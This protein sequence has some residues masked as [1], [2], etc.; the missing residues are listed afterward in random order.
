M[1]NGVLSTIGGKSANEKKLEVIANNMANAL[2]PGFKAVGSAFRS[3][4]VEDASSPDQLPAIAVNNPDNYIQFSDGPVIH[5]GNTLDL[6]IEGQGFFVVSGPNGPLYTRNGQFRLNGA[7]QLITQDGYPV[8]GQS[9][10]NITIDGKNVTIEKDGSIFV[11]KVPVDKVKVV[12]FADKKDLRNTGASLFVNT[13]DANTPVP[14]K[15]SSV[16][17]GSYEASNV[18]I[19]K[20]MVLMIQV[21]RAYE[22]YSKIDQSQATMA[23][24]LLELGKF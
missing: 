6:A 12:D 19:M 1:L 13:N 24:K 8:M 23:D 21:L 10:G 2:T 5:T 14:A 18:D 3:I 4:T 9:G 11:D 22:S 16:A 15:S 7:K 20:E 17:Q